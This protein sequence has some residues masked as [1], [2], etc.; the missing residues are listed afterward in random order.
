MGT[1]DDGFAEL[2]AFFNRTRLHNC[3][4]AVGL[5]IY[6]GTKEIEKTVIARSLL[7]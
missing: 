4:Q 7:N 3:A 5:E 2:M 1:E 6:A